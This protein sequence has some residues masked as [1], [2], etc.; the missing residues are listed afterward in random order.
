[1]SQ[2]KNYKNALLKVFKNESMTVPGNPPKEEQAETDSVPVNPNLQEMILDIQLKH[3]EKTLDQIQKQFD[4]AEGLYSKATQLDKKIA[5]M[6]ETLKALKAESRQLKKDGDELTLRSYLEKPS[7]SKKLP[8]SV[9]RWLFDILH[10]Q[11]GPPNYE[12]LI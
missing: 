7:E 12:E 3:P 10:H 2:I 8:P 1:M 9:N 5:E 11:F 6:E 4:K